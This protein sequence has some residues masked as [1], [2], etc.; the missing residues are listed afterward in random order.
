MRHRSIRIDSGPLATASRRLRKSRLTVPGAILTAASVGAAAVLVATSS[1]APTVNLVHNSTFETSLAGWNTHLPLQTLTRVAGGHTGSYAAELTTPRIGTVALNDSPNTVANTE[2]GTSYAVSAW[3]RVAKPSLSAAVR[4]REVKNGRLVHQSTNS[5]WLT[6]TAWHEVTLQYTTK[7]SGA[8]LDLNVLGWKLAPGNALMID[9]VTMMGPASPAAPA[10][11]P[12]PVVT[13]TPTPTATPVVDP[14]APTPPAP[15]PVPP[16]VDPTPIASSGST[17]FGW[18]VPAGIPFSTAYAQTVSTFGSPDVIRVYYPG[19]PG[20]W[21][22]P[23]GET[24]KPV[25]V[26]FKA[27]PQTILTGADDAALSAWFNAAPTDRTIWWSYYHEPEDNIAA[28]QFTAAQY[29]AAWVHIAALAAAANHPN[30][31]ATLILM[32]WTLSPSSGRTFTDYY[33]GPSVIDTLGWDCY[34]EGYKKGGYDTPA[35]VFG[36]AVALSKSLGKPFGIGE[37]GSQMAVGDDGTGRAAFI[38]QSVAYLRGQG[39][40]FATY[41]DSNTGGT[42]VLNDSPSIHALAASL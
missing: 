5:V 9:D 39:A 37:W 1:A 30:L 17:L 11:A 20:S 15:T 25:I 24:G 18:A 23:A 35:S 10:V 3:V 14:P 27:L 12:A 38:D 32:C 2:A 41:F 7:S 16:V 33:P 4:I 31:K 36:N 42:F 19:L 34:S 6:N 28:G 29:R 8:S 22:G 13:P 26:S 40:S 21:S